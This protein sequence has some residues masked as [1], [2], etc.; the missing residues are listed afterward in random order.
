MG[1]AAKANGVAEPRKQHP[2]AYCKELGHHIN[3]CEKRAARKAQRPANNEGAVKEATVPQSAQEESQRKQH[4][5]AYCKELGH[6]IN[7][8][9]KR[10][11]RKAQS[12]PVVSKGGGGETLSAPPGPPPISLLT[13]QPRKQHPCAYCKEAGHHINDC[14]KR[15]A[16]KAQRLADNEGVAKDATALPVEENG[17]QQKTQVQGKEPKPKKELTVQ[18]LEQQLFVQEN[19]RKMQRQLEE[20]RRRRREEE[21]ARAAGMVELGDMVAPGGSDAPEVAV[22]GG[23]ARTDALPAAPNAAAV[24]GIA[25]GGGGGGARRIKITRDTEEEPK[26]KQERA[27]G[28]GGSG[29]AGDGRGE[30]E[31]QRAARVEVQPQVAGALGSHP[32]GQPP[33]GKIAFR[34][35]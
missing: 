1:V 25:H 15:D 3:D 12:Q 32:R 10:A 26:H 16:K 33:P 8:C 34:T 29:R 9:E 7:D 20:N 23:G 28:R 35:V 4:P 2:C 24:A 13:P 30:Q 5:C 31:A 19:Q 18:Q 6:H 11:F 22:G 14:E 17:S 27:Y 21:V